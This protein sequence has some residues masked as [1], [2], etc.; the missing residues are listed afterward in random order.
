MQIP[1]PLTLY[2]PGGGFKSPTPSDFLPHAFNI[3]ATLLCVGD[4]S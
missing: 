3:G 4:L 2:N 1:I